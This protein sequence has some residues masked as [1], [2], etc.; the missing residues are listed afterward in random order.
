MARQQKHATATPDRDHLAPATAG[1]TE[2]R[3][4]LLDWPAARLV[5]RRNPL[6]SLPIVLRLAEG[7]S[8]RFRDLRIEWRWVFIQYRLQ[9]GQPAALIFRVDFHGRN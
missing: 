7:P 5:P 8:G 1:R 3:S 2:R 4:L 9:L 6:G